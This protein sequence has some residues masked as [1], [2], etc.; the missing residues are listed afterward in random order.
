[1]SMYGNSYTL[2]AYGDIY[3]YGENG[4]EQII[5]PPPSPN[6]SRA[7]VPSLVLQ[8]LLPAYLFDTS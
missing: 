7:A 6:T 5:S 4:H 3:W 1:M 8:T 2:G